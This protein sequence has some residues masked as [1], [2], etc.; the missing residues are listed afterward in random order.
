MPDD[1]EDVAV[2][3]AWG[4]WAVP[5][6]LGAV[7][8]VYFVGIFAE[9]AKTGSTARWLPEPI[10]Y[11]TQVAS[12][13]PNAATF[14]VEFRAEGYRC[15]DKTWAEIDVAPWFPI[16]A[17][18][19]ESR[20]HR[21]VHFYGDQHPQRTNW[22]PHRPTM[23]ALDAFIVDHYDADVVDAAARGQ[24]SSPIGGVRIVR[25]HVPIG[26]PGD[27]AARYER[28]PLAAHDADERK[29]LYYTLE[30]ERKERC[31]LIGR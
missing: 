25:L 18:N 1:R 26:A 24:D 15:R 19:K 4:G 21:V 12:L 6:V 7:S 13:F 10:E 3:R 27:G 22:R 30:S 17:D 9:A 8:I 20:F 2:A 31:A 16:N 23:R 14:A 5:L 28:R 29:D 11:F